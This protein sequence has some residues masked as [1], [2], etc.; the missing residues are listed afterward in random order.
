MNCL[1][2]CFPQKY[3]GAEAFGDI[4]TGR[5]Q[6]VWMTI[7]NYLLKNSY[8]LEINKTTIQRFSIKCR[9]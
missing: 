6:W 2:Y 1:I 3:K 7:S 9:K 5:K 4:I 8:S